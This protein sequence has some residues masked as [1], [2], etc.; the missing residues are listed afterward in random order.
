M[1]TLR[2]GAAGP[3]GGART[4]PRTLVIKNRRTDAASESHNE[5]LNRYFEATWLEIDEA[6]DAAL[7][8]RPSRISLDRLFRGVQD[9]CL[10]GNAE[11]IHK[12]LFSKIETRVNQVEA[13]RLAGEG[14]G[15]DVLTLEALLRLWRKW[16]DKSVG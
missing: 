16:N 7:D 3:F 4:G 13:E 14:R 1:S 5:K 15:D 6:V 2:S 10:S 11:E 9:L 12:R 8:E